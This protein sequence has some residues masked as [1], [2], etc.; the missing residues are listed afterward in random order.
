MIEA[1]HPRTP[2]RARL[3]TFCDPIRSESHPL[4]VA[5]HPHGF[6]T[7]Y[8]SNFNFPLVEYCSTPVTLIFYSKA[9]YGNNIQ[10]STVP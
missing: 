3:P 8:N 4:T 9:W 6:P 5:S 10:Y 7:L 2:S 1:P